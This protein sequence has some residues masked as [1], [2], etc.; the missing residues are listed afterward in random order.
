MKASLL[1]PTYYYAQ[2]SIIRMSSLFMFTTILPHLIDVNRKTNSCLPGNS[3]GLP[4]S[5]ITCADGAVDGEA[6]RAMDG[7]SVPSALWMVDGG[8][9]NGELTPK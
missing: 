1:T 6:L 9:K 8:L 7:G 3:L 4:V 2:I 5:G